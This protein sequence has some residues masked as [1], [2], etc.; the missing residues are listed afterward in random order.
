MA[1]SSST[2]VELNRSFA[3]DRKKSANW[4]LRLVG[5]NRI[6][7]STSSRGISRTL[8]VLNTTVSISMYCWSSRSICT[9]RSQDWYQ[10]TGIGNHSLSQ[11]PIP[12]FQCC[13]LDEKSLSRVSGLHDCMMMK[14]VVIIVQSVVHAC[15][16]VMSSSY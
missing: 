6:Q 12:A 13:M 1:N 8:I 2:V 5:G 9:S 10:Y 14:G 4:V 11:D 16:I 15:Y 7:L 3:C